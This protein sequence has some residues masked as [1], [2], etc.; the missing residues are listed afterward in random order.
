MDRKKKI[1]EQMQ[2]SRHKRLFGLAGYYVED[3]TGPIFTLAELEEY[4]D[5]ARYIRLPMNTDWCLSVVMYNGPYES[6]FKEVCKKDYS[7]Q[8]WDYA[9]DGPPYWSF[10]RIV[11]DARN[12]IGKRKSARAENN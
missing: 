8:F 10:S 3:F 1:D 2:A 5:W 12:Y 4:L 9:N 7:D 6:E 11:D